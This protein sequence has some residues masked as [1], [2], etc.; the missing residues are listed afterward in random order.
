VEGKMD[1]HYHRLSLEEV[2]RASEQI[3]ISYTSAYKGL[4]DSA[5][6]KS[7][8]KHHWSPILQNS[9]CNGDTC[10]I[11]TYNE[12]IIGSSVFGTTTTEEGKCAEWHAFYLLPQYAG[13]GIGHP[14][15]QIIEK[16][17]IKQGCQSCALEVLSSNKRAI[18]FYLSHGFEKIQVFEVE[19]YG[20]ILSCDKM[21]KKL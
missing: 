15:Y 1:I 5:Y 18:R 8:S 11:A 14:F 9:I 3:T 13:R 20:M 7:I 19:E 10:I 16:E 12:I 17:M 21:I 4:M 2:D 6:L